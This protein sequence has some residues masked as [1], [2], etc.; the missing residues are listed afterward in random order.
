MAGI[1][2]GEGFLYASFWVV[3]ICDYR[4]VWVSCMV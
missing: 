1:V 4:A 3:Q 2:A